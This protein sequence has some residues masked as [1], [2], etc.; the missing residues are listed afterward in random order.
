MEQVIIE[1]VQYNVCTDLRDISLI[2]WS[3]L[4][5][6]L[7]RREYIIDGETINGEEVKREIQ[8]GNESDAF[9]WEQ[10]RDICV[11]L[12]DIPQELLDEYPELLQYIIP[13]FGLIT[14]NEQVEIDEMTI[15]GVYYAVD[16]IPDIT[17]G[18]W[19]D[20]EDYAK[21]EPI[22]VLA[23]L[24]RRDGK[25]YNRW[26]PD[27]TEKIAVVENLNA[28]EY[29][30]VINWIQNNMNWV[31]SSFPFVYGTEEDYEMSDYKSPNMDD[32]CQKFGWQHTINTLAETPVFNSDKG[33]LYGVRNADMLSVLEYLNILRSK[34]QAEHKDFKLNNSKHKQSI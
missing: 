17:F 3:R 16:Q 15:N 24:M 22:Y 25:V 12:S 13:L 5:N 7:N 9:M 30:P 29:A 10:E 34:Q 8:R 21:M 11:L 28:A 1:D 27:W 18:Q 23:G 31:R 33:T 32:H 19:A 2:K 4:I 20:I 6:I 26:Q 14:T